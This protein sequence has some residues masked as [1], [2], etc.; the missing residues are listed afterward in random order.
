MLTLI[1]GYGGNRAFEIFAD[2]DLNGDHHVVN[3]FLGGPNG[4]LIP[5]GLSHTYLAEIPPGR[6]Y[7]FVIAVQGLFVFGKQR[8]ISVD[9]LLQQGYALRVTYSAPADHG[10]IQHLL[11][12]HPNLWTGEVSSGAAHLSKDPPK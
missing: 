6:Q 8:Q 12:Q 5:I 1:S 2:S 10:L 7:E 11:V 4:Q 3:S 9:E